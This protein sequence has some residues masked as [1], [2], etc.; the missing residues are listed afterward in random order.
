[1]TDRTAEIIDLDRKARDAE[2]MAEKSPFMAD[3][4]RFADIAQDYRRRAAKLRE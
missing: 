4:K 2:R 1:M 3:R